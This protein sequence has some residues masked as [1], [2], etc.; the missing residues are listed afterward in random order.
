[1]KKLISIL[2]LISML[3]LCIAAC[4]GDDNTNNGTT[5]TPLSQQEQYDLALSLLSE[6]KYSE[7]YKL[8]QELGD[9][10]DSKDYVAHFHY[11]PTK[12]ILS[13]GETTQGMR[14]TLNEHNLPKE[15][16]YSFG[17]DEQLLITLG[18]DQNG[19]LIKTTKPLDGEQEAVTNYI[20]NDSGKLIKIDFYNHKDYTEYTYDDGGKLV[21]K[22]YINSNP[23]NHDIYEYFYDDNGRLI[24]ETYKQGP[25][26]DVSGYITYTYDTDNQLIKETYT[27]TALAFKSTE[28]HYT[29]DKNGRLVKEE[30]TG[31]NDRQLTSEYFYNE[32]GVLCEI[33]ETMPDY[34]FTEKIEYTLVYIA[35]DLSDET[36]QFLN[37]QMFGN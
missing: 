11:I 26:N 18:F 30:Q 23:G 37:D 6:T 15:I 12:L 21:K 4:G 33:K 36:K 32:D 29:Y 2:L 28:T 22:V 1:M 8:F 20:Y 14:T 25:N 19:K 3:T 7:A 24:K 9:Y 27:D 31:A 34:T 5:T 16:F 17:E 35:C 13:D 10:E